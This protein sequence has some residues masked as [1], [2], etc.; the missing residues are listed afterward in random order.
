[1]VRGIMMLIK[2]NCSMVR[3]IFLKVKLAS[4][5]V[6]SVPSERHPAPV[7]PFNDSTQWSKT[8]P[9]PAHRIGGGDRSLP[10]AAEESA[11]RQQSSAYV[12]VDHGRS[13]RSDRI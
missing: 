7:I 12:Y 6:I 1:L 10:V 9:S 3:A 5:K 4:S 11:I 13:R 8:N 2:C